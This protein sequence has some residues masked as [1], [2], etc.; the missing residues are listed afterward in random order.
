MSARV[1]VGPRTQQREVGLWVRI[2]LGEKNRPCDTHDDAIAEVPGEQSGQ[3]VANAGVAE[4]D[5]RHFDDLTVEE[6]HTVVLGE[7][8]ELGHP[9]ILVDCE[10]STLEID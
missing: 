6:L 3:P 10:S 2:L 5:R 9:V 7:N 4:A 1:E 8:P